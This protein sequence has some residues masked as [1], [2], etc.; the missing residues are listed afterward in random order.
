LGSKLKQFHNRILRTWVQGLAAEDHHH[1]R[2]KKRAAGDV[3]DDP[4]PKKHSNSPPSAEIQDQEGTK[5]IAKE[6]EDED[7]EEEDEDE[8]E[9]A[10]EDEDGDERSGQTAPL[11]K[12]SVLPKKN[13]VPGPKPGGVL[14]LISKLLQCF[15]SVRVARTC[16][17]GGVSAAC[18]PQG[19][20]AAWPV[21]LQAAARARVLHQP[22]QASA[23]AITRM[24]A[25]VCLR[26]SPNAGVHVK[27]HCSLPL[28][29]S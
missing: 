15:V 25:V 3:K 1:K 4:A 18:H 28:S 10:D 14:T 2:D 17:C 16:C 22:F 29:P 11:K 21:V 5:H 9:N 7:E 6:D 23:K 24:Q 27:S 13:S 20:A 8:E 12:K 19:P 26:C